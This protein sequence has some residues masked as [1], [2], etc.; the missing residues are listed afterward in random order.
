MS[1]Q[2]QDLQAAVF[3]REKET[4]QSREWGNAREKENPVSG[5]GR[6]KGRHATLY[7]RVVSATR[8]GLGES[9]V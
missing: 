5:R 1:L 9:Q 6:E 2:S 7:I 4:S 3:T 8:E